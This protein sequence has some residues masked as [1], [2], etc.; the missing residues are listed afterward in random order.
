MF[1]HYALTIK[2]HIINGVKLLSIS[3]KVELKLEIEILWIQARGN[4]L[5]MS[6]WAFR[7]FLYIAKSFSNITQLFKLS[8]L[9]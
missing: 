1:L 3:N 2:R 5:M 6:T 7:K 4:D 9:S 8:F